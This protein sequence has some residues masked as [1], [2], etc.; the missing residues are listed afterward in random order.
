V[1][2]AAAQGP[3]VQDNQFVNVSSNVTDLGADTDVP[4]TIYVTDGNTILITK[5]YGNTWVNRSVSNSIPGVTAISDILVDPRNR[6]IVYAVT[7][8]ASGGTFGRAYQSLN[9]GRTWTDI[10]VNLPDLPVWKL[11]LDPRTN[12]LYLGNDN[13]VW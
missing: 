10:T 6:E 13:G 11:V 12:S 8:Q 1:A 5:N 3:Y 4:S 7:N 2:L 9:S